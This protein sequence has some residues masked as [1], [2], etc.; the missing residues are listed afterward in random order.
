[1]IDL[2]QVQRAPF[3]S[4][5][6]YVHELRHIFAW[7]AVAGLVEGNFAAFMVAKIFHA[8]PLLI[9]IA[10]T[11]PVA[12][13]LANLVWGMLC[14]GRPKV[15][16]MTLSA[17]GV[18][19]MTGAVTLVPV[20]PLGAW[21][22]VA[23]MAAA[24]FFMTGIVSTRS[25]M[26]KANYPQWVRGQ[27]AARVQ[28]VRTLTQLVALGAGA[29]VLNVAPAFYRWLYPVVA[30]IGVIAI[31]LLQRL[32]VRGERALLARMHRGEGNGLIEP[33]QFWAVLSPM[34]VLAGAARV[35]RADAGFRQYCTA[36]MFA[37]CANL[38]VRSVVVAV[39]A[40]ELLDGMP[41][42]FWVGVVL[43][44]VLPR[45][46][47]M[48]C[49]ARFAAYYDRVGVLRFRVVHGAC[50]LVA[51]LFGM[52]GAWA[53]SGGGPPGPAGFVVGMA[54][55]IAFGVMRGICYGG[56]Q[57]AWNLGH[58]HFARH[59]DAEVYMGIHVSL[60]GVRGLLLPGA[61][62]LLW[63]G[64]GAWT[65]IGWWVWGLACGFALIALVSFAALAR[66][67]AARA[68]PEGHEQALPALQEVMVRK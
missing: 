68:A 64:V 61:G 35:L 8:G 12:A 20:S 27:L 5:G 62:M 23:Q 30:L 58:L 48:A 18:V 13:H 53:L 37:G 38:L 22:F 47:M 16:M 67:D 21:V 17:A 55:F 29:A 66:T 7:G 3:L 41:A 31:I 1:V 28:V 11:T 65:G 51:L 44:D 43:L 59:E 33:Q 46:L 26:W 60:T 63:H 42:S 36:Q 4:R 50:W 39:I 14:V 40:Q 32:H 52:C 6:N 57:I 10:A 25:A 45:L 2:F 15:R 34:R 19:L 49:M 56:G 54:C 9:A 24:Q